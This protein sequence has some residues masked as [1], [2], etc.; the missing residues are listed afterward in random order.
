MIDVSA[1]K[2]IDRLR[3]VALLLQTENNH[4]H[5]RLQ[6]LAGD[7][8]AALQLEI[9]QLQEKLSAAQKAMYGASSEKR[10]T[11]PGSSKV[12][13][14]APPAKQTGHGPT[15]Q[16]KLQLVVDTVTLLEKDR[17]C[18]ECG[19]YLP[20]MA[21]QFEISKTID[22]VERSFHIVETR[23]QKY[24]CRCSHVVTAPVPPRLIPGGRYTIGFASAV[25]VAKYL[26]HMPLT[27]Q[28]RQMRRQGLQVTSQ[29]LWDQIDA[30]AKHLEPT[31][32]AIRDRILSEPVV[33]ADETTWRLMKKGATKK[34]WVWSVS[35]PDAVWYK[36]GP[37]RSKEAA[38]ELL[39]DF[40]GTIV[41][42]GYSA[43]S[44]MVKDRREARAGPD[45]AVLAHC[46]AHVR[47]KFFE[48]SRHYDE[49][50]RALDL[51]GR[52]Y[53][54]EREAAV[55]DDPEAVLLRRADLRQQQS[56]VVVKSLR[57][58][59]AQQRVLPKSSIGRAIHY[60]DGIWSGLE[61]FLTDP[62]IPLD[63]NQTERGMRTVAVGRKNHYGSKSLRGTQVAAQLYTLIETAKLVGV[64]PEEYLYAAA[65]KAVVRPGTITLPHDFKK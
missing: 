1:E 11:K 32:H 29:A 36:I 43:Y 24:R 3:Q 37:S 35:S 53:E 63:N 42:D 57:M 13:S 31:Y 61:R 47:R 45:P 19:E 23:R 60:A 21:G 8:P 50:E 49:A 22:V 51:I 41:C 62:R 9:E 64:N 52:L 38:R 14:E 54:I 20:E 34:W 46:W 17:Q 26:D 27:R 5:R 40:E 65:Y 48:A 2:D 55:A 33:G 16:G 10:S 12:A 18:T 28:E 25:A 56:S 7:D 44:A 58:W 6:D 39:K 30:L 59:M 15:E 4:L